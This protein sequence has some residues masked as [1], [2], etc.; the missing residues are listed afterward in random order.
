MSDFELFTEEHY[1]KWLEWIEEEPFTDCEKWLKLMN[2]LAS[3]KLKPVYYMEDNENFKLIDLT[4]EDYDFSQESSTDTHVFY[5]TSPQPIKEDEEECDHMTGIN[6]TFMA[7][8]LRSSGNDGKS[9]R[10]L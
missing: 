9:A 7:N 6:Y 2:S 5:M 8:E 10:F 4:N 3:E 1:K